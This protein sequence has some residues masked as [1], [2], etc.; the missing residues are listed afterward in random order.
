MPVSV[1]TSSTALEPSL[2]DAH[3]VYGVKTLYKET[4][5]HVDFADDAENCSSS[6]GAV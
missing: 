6:C 5:G 3:L 2:S 4:E 1:Q